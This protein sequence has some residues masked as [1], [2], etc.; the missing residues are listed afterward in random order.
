MQHFY[1]AHLQHYYTT[2]A[3][4]AQY[5]QIDFASHFNILSN[6]C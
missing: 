5:N 3:F 4:A 6:D 2:T 1:E